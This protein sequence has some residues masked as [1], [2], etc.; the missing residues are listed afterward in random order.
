MTDL[1]TML[2]QRSHENEH[3]KTLLYNLQDDLASANKS[4]SLTVATFENRCHQ[5]D[6][7]V[8][9]TKKQMLEMRAQLMDAESKCQ[10]HLDDKKEYKANIVQLQKAIDDLAAQKDALRYDNGILFG[11][12]GGEGKGEEER[13]DGGDVE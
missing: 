4:A 5:L 10:R 8:E 11:G 6:T 1:E 7:E 13:Q 12:R 9:V 3:L 2:E